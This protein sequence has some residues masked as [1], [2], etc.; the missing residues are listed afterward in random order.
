MKAAEV[1]QQVCNLDGIDIQEGAHGE[2]YER[3]DFN[4]KAGIVSGHGH[5][6]LSKSRLNFYI[7][8]QIEGQDFDIE[9]TRQDGYEYVTFNNISPLWATTKIK[10]DIVVEINVY[11]EFPDNKSWLFSTKKNQ[12]FLTLDEPG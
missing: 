9:H 10:N 3:I 5:Y 11:E 7:A 1:F 6:E 8:Y 2:N 4:Y 12:R